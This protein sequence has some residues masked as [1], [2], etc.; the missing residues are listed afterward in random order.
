MNEMIERVT[1]AI[2]A[3]LEQQGVILSGCERAESDVGRAAIEAMRECTDAMKTAGEIARDVD[4]HG[5][6]WTY[7]AMIDA[8]LKTAE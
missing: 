3:K 8:A 2:F 1:E 6:A 5:V 7:R 4:E